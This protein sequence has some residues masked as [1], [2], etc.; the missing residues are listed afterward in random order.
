MSNSIVE[1][2]PVAVVVLGIGTLLWKGGMWVGRVNTDVSGLQDF[3]REIREVVMPEIRRDIKRIFERL[4]APIAEENSPLRLTDYGK[5]MAEFLEAHEWATE[6][7]P[8]LVSRVRGKEPF[9]VDEFA[10][11]YVADITSAGDMERRV[12]ACAYEFGRQR[13]EIPVVLRIAL[14]EELLRLTE[15]PP[16][17]IRA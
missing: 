16:T 17:S 5:R 15:S 12:A 2:A 13:S 4:P 3:M 7:A 8:S 11:E 9:E 10:E 6:V 14:R 1:W